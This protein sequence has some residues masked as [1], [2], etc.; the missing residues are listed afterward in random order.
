MRKCT[1]VSTRSGFRTR[2]TVRKEAFPPTR[3]ILVPLAARDRGLDSARDQDR[4]AANLDRRFRGF[5]V[6]AAS[7]QVPRVEERADR[8]QRAALALAV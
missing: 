8:D 1:Q 3:N 4:V 5:P 2:E 6:L 7:S